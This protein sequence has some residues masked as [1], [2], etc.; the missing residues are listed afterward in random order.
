MV[1]TSESIRILDWTTEYLISALQPIKPF[2]GW[3]LVSVSYSVIFSLKRQ[4]AEHCLYK[5]SVMI[6]SFTSLCFS[7]IGHA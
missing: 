2:S 6:V 5:F 3:K 7:N 1:L 4:V